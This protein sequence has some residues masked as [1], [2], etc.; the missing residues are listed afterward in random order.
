MALPVACCGRW[1]RWAMRRS[2]AST[3]RVERLE[4]RRPKWKPATPASLAQ[5]MYTKCPANCRAV[6]RYPGAV[7]AGAVISHQLELLLENA[8]NRS[9]S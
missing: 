2:F 7:P 6:R 5:K 8:V 4:N 9:N 1:G 3:E